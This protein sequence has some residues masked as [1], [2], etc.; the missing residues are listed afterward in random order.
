[1]DVLAT[2]LGIAREDPN[3]RAVLLHGSRAFGEVD[4]YS[5]YDVVLATVSNEPYLAGEDADALDDTLVAR[6]VRAFG[7]IAV[8]Q[9]PD[10]GDPHEFFTQ[11]LQ[12][13]GGLRVDLT[14]RPVA[15]LLRDGPESATVVL[16]DRDG[17]FA[18]TPPPS[19]ADF[20]LTP[21]DA[22]AFAL[23]RNEF[24]WCA[25]YV[26]KAVTRHQLPHALELLAD[27]VRG[28]Y[29]T[30]L[31]WLAGARHDWHAVNPGKHLSRLTRYLAENDATFVDAWLASY[32][33]AHPPG[34]R[35]ALDGLM[36][37]YGPLATTVAGLLGYDDDPAEGER[38]RRLI[39]DVFP[40]L[41]TPTA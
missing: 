20:W 12:F 13:A 5:D 41:D 35:A 9:T 16:L 32:V 6:L 1:M 8:A 11:L 18:D 10:N 27:P 38:T 37:A 29:A 21:P 25:P 2:L 36:S 14:C 19:D 31:A 15:A 26:A 34:I 40:A 28:E 17:R 24:W 23:H 3:I 39:S 7:E 30:M 33:S 22:A 4:A